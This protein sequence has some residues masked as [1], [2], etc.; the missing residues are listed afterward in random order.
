M[1]AT[2]RELGGHHTQATLHP[3]RPTSTPVGPGVWTSISTTTAQG[4]PR[5]GPPVNV[6]LRRAIKE[7]ATT[8]QKNSHD[9]KEISS[10]TFYSLPAVNYE[11]A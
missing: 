6:G 4:H 7:N 8:P 11:E 2:S 10:L 5:G 1:D 9:K 3:S